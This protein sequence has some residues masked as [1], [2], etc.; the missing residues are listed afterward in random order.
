MGNIPAIRHYLW[1]GESFATHCV[2]QSGVLTSFTSLYVVKLL[3][4]SF[5]KE[6]VWEN[7]KIVSTRDLA[8]M[9]W[10]S[11][12][13]AFREEL[14]QFNERMFRQRYPNSK[15]RGRFSLNS[16]SPLKR[17]V[18]EKGEHVTCLRPVKAYSSGYAGLPSCWFE[19]GDVVVV[20]AVDVPAVVHE[21]ENPCDRF[22]CVDFEKENIQSNAAHPKSNQGWRCA[23]YYHHLLPLSNYNRE[24]EKIS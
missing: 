14:D 13:S 10:W 1:V 17:Y 6:R 22:V 3:Q 4:D 19:P 18:P 20:G 23:M 5:V 7:G 15:S 21:P 16:R 9:S 11:A 2:L 24:G 12:L 8:K